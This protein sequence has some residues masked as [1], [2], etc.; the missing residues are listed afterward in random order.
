M[1]VAFSQIMQEKVNDY[2]V[3]DG[4]FNNAYK[5]SDVTTHNKIKESGLQLLA[6][7]VR[8]NNMAF[9]SKIREYPNCDYSVG[10]LRP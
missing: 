3:R 6:I 8:T 10:R 4:V 2:R 7:T 1:N 9:R 5:V